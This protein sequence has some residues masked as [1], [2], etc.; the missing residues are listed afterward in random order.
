SELA[1]ERIVSIARLVFVL[2]VIGGGLA[3]LAVAGLAFADRV[4]AHVP[5]LTATVGYSIHGVLVAAVVALSLT[6]A[7]RTLRLIEGAARA[8]VVAS[9]AEQ[10]LRTVLHAHHDLR[11]VVTSAQINADL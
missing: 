8:A 11:T 1:A 2:L 9:K 7:V 10:G 3:V 5:A 6:I 4:F